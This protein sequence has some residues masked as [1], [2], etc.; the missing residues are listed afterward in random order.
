MTVVCTSTLSVPKTQMLC[1]ELMRLS[2][3]RQKKTAME[4]ER[5]G[6]S[7]LKHSAGF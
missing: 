3:K 6:K 7:W 1:E 5:Y 2:R 4:G